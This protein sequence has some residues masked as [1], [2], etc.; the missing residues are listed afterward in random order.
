MADLFVQV[1]KAPEG[2]QRRT[3]KLSPTSDTVY[4]GS[5]VI[6][7]SDGTFGRMLG[8]HV[9]ATT[10][11]PKAYICID[12]VGSLTPDVALNKRITVLADPGIQIFTNNIDVDAAVGDKVW[13]GVGRD[14]TDDHKLMA[15]ITLDGSSDMMHG[16][17]IPSSKAFMTYTSTPF[18]VVDKIETGVGAYVTLL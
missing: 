5:L 13:A 3:E 12:E 11:A 6:A 1:K 17:L 2:F 4:N 9:S 10:K 16:I 18:G 8:T 14:T 7:Q 15:N